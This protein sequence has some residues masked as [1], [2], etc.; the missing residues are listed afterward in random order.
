MLIGSLEHEA[1]LHPLGRRYF[2]NELVRS[3]TVRLRLEDFTRRHPAVAQAALPPLTV[4]TGFPRTGTTFLHHLLAQ[5]PAFR[6]FA[7]WELLTPVPPTRGPVLGPEGVAATIER[8]ERLL[9]LPEARRRSNSVH[10]FRADAP[11][12]CWPLLHPSFLAGMF[13]LYAHLPSYQAWRAR[14]DLTPAFRTYRRLLQV[15]TFEKPPATRLLVKSPGHLGNLR[16]LHAVF[17]E[18]RV[19]CTHR[20]PAEVA[21][22]VCSMTAEARRHFSDHVDPRHI[23]RQVLDD[24]PPLAWG[25]ELRKEIGAAAFI[26]VRYRDLVAE[27]MATARRI[28]DALDMPFAEAQE[29]A[30]QAFLERNRRER[31]GVRHEYRLED[32]GLDR[33]ELRA[34]GREYVE[35]FGL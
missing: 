7:Y 6:V 29:R 20:D 27:P 32:Y 11:E 21:G 3:L 33:A 12:E 19:I 35:L 23:G 8:R 5:D 25:L 26:D 2:H 31:Q 17:P 28:Y 14:Q 1:R 10:Q 22:S 30:F 15:L 16:F 34:M 4:I 24:T 18:V 9:Y 13:G